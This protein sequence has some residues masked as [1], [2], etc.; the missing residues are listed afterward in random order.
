MASFFSSTNFGIFF[1]LCSAQAWDPWHDGGEDTTVTEVFTRTHVVCPCDSSIETGLEG[2]NVW[3]STTREPHSPIGLTTT[4]GFHYLN[5]TTTVPYTTSYPSLSTTS[6]TWIPSTSSETTS[7]SYLTSTSQTTFTSATTTTTTE[8]PLYITTTSSTSTS[9]STTLLAT[10][11]STTSESS[12]TTTADLAT[13]TTTVDSTST[14]TDSTTTTTDSTT[15]TTTTTDLTTTTTIDSTTTTADPTSTTTGST[16]TTADS[17]TTTTDSTTT[18]TTESTTT[19]TMEPTTTTTTTADLATT[20]TTTDSTSTTTDSTTTT[21]TDSTT[22]T[23]T[24][25][26]TTTT[27]E[28][29]TTTTTTTTTAVPLPT[30]V[31]FITDPGFESFYPVTSSQRDF[32]KNGWTFSGLVSPQS[33]QQ[34]DLSVFLSSVWAT[35]SFDGPVVAS[36]YISQAVDLPDPIASYALKYSFGLTTFLNTVSCEIQA[37][38]AGMVFDSFTLSELVDPGSPGSTREAWLPVRGF[39]TGDFR[40]TVSC[41]RP[42][43]APAMA[44]RLSVDDLVL[45]M[46]AENGCMN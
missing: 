28:S 9:S 6:L 4:T 18:T 31:N 22:T 27:M 3:T 37:S 12:T 5:T 23:T 40:L 33:S 7:P 25:S 15:T 11:S 17:T 14:T 19:T 24:D 42:P 43:I 29:T 44:V 45:M 2:W 21:T 30:C 8:T 26:T 41:K 20:T 10:T 32:T 34:T 39:S 36:G 13:T 35:F 38:F 16:T 46:E 1:L